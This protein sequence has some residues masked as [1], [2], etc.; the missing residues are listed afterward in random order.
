MAG[1]TKTIDVMGHG[2][3]YTNP[4]FKLSEFFASIERHVR[5]S[6]DYTAIDLKAASKE[7][8]AAITGYVNKLDKKPRDKIIYISP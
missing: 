3:F 4:R 6:A 5:K 7:Q 8:I 1:T 2:S